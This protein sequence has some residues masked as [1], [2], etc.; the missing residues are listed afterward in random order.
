MSREPRNILF[1]CTHNSARSI[2]AE[3]LANELGD[4]RFK[5]FSAGSQ[6]S[7][8]VNPLALK[9]LR[10]LG[11]DT[12]GMHSKSWDVYAGPDAPQMDFIITVCDNA[13]GEVCPVW[14]GKPRTAHWGFADPS[15]VEGDEEARR[16]AFKDT[17][18][19]IA[20]RLR[21]FLRLPHQGLA[22]D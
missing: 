5:G 13:A 7:G 16:A 9:T 17:A 14:P 4:G 10:S 12:E 6:P 21:E 2:M 19:A 22:G 20:D 3:G 11:I 1:L 8:K 15:C 18:D